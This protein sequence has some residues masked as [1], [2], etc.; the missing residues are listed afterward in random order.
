MIA[1]GVVY[2]ARTLLIRHDEGEDNTGQEVRGGSKGVDGV[3]AAA[4][5][6]DRQERVSTDS[7][8]IGGVKMKIGISMRTEDIRR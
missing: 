2:G 6:A 7:V 1:S 3:N 8:D 5:E 4:A